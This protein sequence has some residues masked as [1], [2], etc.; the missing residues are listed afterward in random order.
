VCRR[1]YIVAGA[2]RVHA[3]AYGC[4]PVPAASCACVCVHGCQYFH[5]WIIHRVLS[6]LIMDPTCISIHI[7]CGLCVVHATHSNNSVSNSIR[8]ELDV[9]EFGRLKTVAEECL[10]YAISSVCVFMCGNSLV[11]QV[12]MIHLRRALAA[13]AVSFY[14]VL[15]LYVFWHCFSLCVSVHTSAV[16]ARRARTWAI[17]GTCKRARLCVVTRPSLLKLRPSAR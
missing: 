1:V 3:Y 13:Q 14:C 16:C 9:Y 6:V 8:K 12:E 5:V 15:F 4:C 2:L 10:F 11:C 17:N 7:L